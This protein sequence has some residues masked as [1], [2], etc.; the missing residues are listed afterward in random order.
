MANAPHDHVHRLIRSMSRAEKRY[1]KL[2]IARHVVGGRSNHGTLF[3]A[4]A[5][6]EAYDEK[7]LLERF[8]GMT[9]TRRFPIAKRRLYEAIL[10]SLD[11]FHADSSVDARL[12]RMLHQAEILAQRA[13]Y[14][15]EAR[16][17]RSIRQLAR[18]HDRQTI[19]LDVLERERR[20]IERTN[21]AGSDERTLDALT[22]RS[23]ALRDEVEQVEQLWHLKGRAFLLLYR[24]GRV[25]DKAHAKVL[26]D[27]ERHP[28]LRDPRQLLTVRARFLHHHVRSAIAFAQG[29]LATCAIH[30]AENH[31]LLRRE[32]QRFQDE[33]N[34]LFSVLSNR[35]YVLS[36]LGDRQGSESL[37]REFRML[38][39]TLPAAPS[40]DLEVKVFAT[41]ASLELAMLTRSGQFTRAAEKAVP[42]AERLPRF[43]ALLAP[44]RKAGLLLQLAWVH[45]GA[46][47]PEKAL[48]YSHRQL[49]E[50]TPEDR[51]TVH[52]CGRLLN[53]LILLDLD[54]RDL[55]PY[56]L[57]NTERDLA[58][59]RSASPMERAIMDHV[60]ER[61][62]ARTAEAVKETLARLH[63]RLR[64]LMSD[65]GARALSDAF[66]PLAWAEARL[67]GRGLEAVVQEG[68]GA[69]TAAQDRKGRRAA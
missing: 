59:D 66:D 52:R 22:R 32:E 6:M 29:D 16:L 34:L 36:L 50:R 51:A 54:R 20:L 58:G 28:L 56:A 65:P 64:P 68:L 8:A 17:L 25:D 24:E 46:G 9:F 43:E 10:A 7:A 4:I 37:L 12:R 48:R 23:Q 1:F 2:Y 67:T 53:L 49:R 13:L 55:L 38:P 57:R 42:I 45:L 11:A 40:A 61:L 15:D 35:I 33:P 27:L 63:D 18:Q 60:H 26:K 21:H 14:A 3:D 47:D 69:R 62:K 30:L 5:A 31:A 44:L 39:A 41:G 19:L